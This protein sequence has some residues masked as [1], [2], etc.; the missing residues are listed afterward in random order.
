MKQIQ[1]RVTKK[2]PSCD[3]CQPQRDGTYSVLKTQ[4]KLFTFFSEK[5]KL[6]LKPFFAQ[7]HSEI[8]AHKS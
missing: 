5:K 2:P 7:T 4:T 1:N 3:T 8:R 6:H